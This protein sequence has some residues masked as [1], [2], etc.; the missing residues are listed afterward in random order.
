MEGVPAMTI[1]RIS[2]EA[3]RLR[4]GPRP[5]GP[6]EAVQ[7]A[8]SMLSRPMPYVYGT[9]TYKLNGVDDPWTMRK[10]GKVGSD[11]AGFVVWCYKL[12][13]HRPGFNKGPW[14]SVADDLNTNSMLEDAYH[15]RELFEPC[16][17]PEVGCLLA[18]PTIRIWNGLTRKQFIGHV[19]IVI[20]TARVR[21]W[22]P[23]LPDY[24]SL[25]VLHCHGPDGRK[26]AVTAST[27]A[28]WDRHDEMWPKP[29]HR[30][31]MIRVK[32]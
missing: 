32:Q 25:D 26:P 31:G 12:P 7:R 29:Q 23:A 1:N 9:G 3:D 14:A 4:G 22:D 20:G 19:C 21:E 13:R 8:Y 27:G 18:Y 15:Q 17:V 24:S 30:T 28:I 2:T 10:D 16:E 6:N 11:C 5:C